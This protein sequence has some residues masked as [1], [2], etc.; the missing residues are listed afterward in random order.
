[1]SMALPEGCIEF[2]E[3]TLPKGSKI[4]ELGSGEGTSLLLEKGFEMFS[5][6]QDSEWA[7]KYHDNYI[8]SSLVLDKTTGIWWF[9]PSDL[10]GKLPSD[11]DLIL[12]DGPTGHTSEYDNC[13]LGFLKN[14]KLFNKNVPILVDDINRPAERELFNIL[15]EG[16]ESSLHHAVSPQEWPFVESY[17]YIQ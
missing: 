7:F 2:L 16:R 10:K 1:M 8:L 12:I 13:R 6:E 15:K 3:R 4:L 5:V 17:G 9:N 14:Q 11:Y